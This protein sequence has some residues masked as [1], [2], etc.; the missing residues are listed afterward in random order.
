MIEEKFNPRF[1]I[2][3]QQLED[4][5]QVTFNGDYEGYTRVVPLRDIKQ[6][7]GIHH[8]TKAAFQALIRGI[9]LR[10]DSK[11]KIYPY[12]N[13]TIDVFER[14]P[15]GAKI[16]QTFILRRK[17]ESIME[18][19]EKQVFNKFIVKGLSKRSPVQV[20]GLDADRKKAIAIYET[21]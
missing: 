20:Y 10:M 7:K 19:L 16:G 4:Q 9:P 18:G 2:P 13:S 21:P 3:I 12:Q 5:L 15:K 8:F 1:D 11:N 6:V 17:V 14:E